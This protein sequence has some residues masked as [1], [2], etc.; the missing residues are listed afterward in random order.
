[1]VVG[2][3]GEVRGLFC[4]WGLTGVGVETLSEESFEGLVCCSIFKVGVRGDAGVLISDFVMCCCCCCSRCWQSVTVVTVS[5]VFSGLGAT[6]M[7]SWQGVLS[8]VW[9]MTLVAMALQ[10]WG[11]G[12]REGVFLAMG[13]RTGWW[14]LEL[15]CCEA[16]MLDVEFSTK[17]GL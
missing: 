2:G 5:L 14:S 17:L 15:Q 12:G 1:M 7:W 3:A 6:G 10:C 8:A 16:I 11:G 4:G 9:R 13:A